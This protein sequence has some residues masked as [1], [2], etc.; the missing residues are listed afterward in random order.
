MKKKT[1]SSEDE[2]NVDKSNS[3]EDESNVDKSK[4]VERK[5][6]RPDVELPKSLRADAGDAIISFLK[7]RSEEFGGIPDPEDLKMTQNVSTPTRTVIRYQQLKNKIPILDSYVVTQLD[8]TGEVKQL[9]LGVTSKTNIVKPASIAARATKI[10]PQEALKH[11]SSIGD[12]IEREK[13]K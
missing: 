9:D 6:F 2:S 11:A 7:S 8:K 3:S 10:T 5:K 12:F 1:N 13:I 4:Y